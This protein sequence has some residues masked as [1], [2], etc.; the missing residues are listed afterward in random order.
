MALL[1][2]NGKKWER[3][4]PPKTIVEPTKTIV[5]RLFNGLQILVLTTFILTILLLGSLLTILIIW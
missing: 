4:N 5:E 2:W 1:R 3:V